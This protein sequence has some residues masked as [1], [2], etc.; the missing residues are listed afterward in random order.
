MV[1]F[2]NVGIHFTGEYLFQNVSF[3]INPNDKIA[4]VG[5]NGTG[6]T[7]LL[8]MLVGLE[9]PSDG[10][11][12]KKKELSTGYLPQEIVNRSNL[13]LFEEV[14]S[15]L[16]FIS[17]IEEKEKNIQL[18]LD[19]D[20]QV[21]EKVDKA[22]H[23][24]SQLNNTKET[25]GYYSIDS[26]IKKILE[27]LGFADKVIDKKM[28][29]FSGG[30]QMRAEMAKILLGNHDMILMDEPTNHLDLD[31]LEW[32]IDYLQTYDG[33]LILVSHD[34]HFVNS[35]TNKTIEIFNKKV[36]F[37]NGNY[38]K[39][40][41]QKEERDRLLIAQHKNLEKKLAQTRRFIERFRYK[42]TKAKQV[43]SR[44]KQLEKI[45]T[46]DLPE[47]E[48]EV[49]IRFPQPPRSGVIPAEVSD[50]GMSFG[51][52][53]V[54]DKLNFKIE[55]GDKIAF[56][57][58]NG[59]GKTTLAKII[60]GIL[61]P[62]EGQV[63]FG[64]NVLL[65]YYAQEVA[66]DLDMDADLLDTISEQ[67]PDLTPGQIRG[68]LGSFLFSDDD[69]FKKV[70]VLSGGE[71]SRLALAKIL[72]TPANLIILDE[73]TNHLDFNSKKILQKA[74]MDFDGTLIIVSHDIDFLNPVINKV[75]ELRNQSAKFY[76]GNIDYYLRKRNEINSGNVNYDREKSS[77]QQMDRKKQKRDEAELRQKKFSATK[78]LKIEIENVESDIHKTENLV[79]TLEK[80]LTQDDIYTNP[81]LAKQK[82]TDYQLGKKKLEELYIKWE[83]LHSKLEEIENQFK[84]NS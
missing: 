78:D 62:A 4:L 23:D 60:S 76:Y 1:D 8:R 67:A 15:S 68:M 20:S 28:N 30:W 26:K 21:K 39:Y 77:L 58:P 35:L 59:A 48:K 17:E 18:I 69:V 44:I 52:L 81:S 47:F 31:S 16:D 56:V 27:G 19:D 43:Q 55:R 49:N 51:S 34:R 40:L 10:T 33:A 5:S 6:K 14:R 53:K 36:T 46:I 22:I 61:H 83:E 64:Y 3:R 13:P 57:G 50:L 45:E 70:K 82:N 79:T 71:K 84:A 32:L 75:L 24:L 29:Q 9:E 7:T 25:L 63:K 72:V 38:D 54:F 41:E 2:S 73:P 74:L 11:I 80:E 37:F 65:S 66:D 42:N 12:H